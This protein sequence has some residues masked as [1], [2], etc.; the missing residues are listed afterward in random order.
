MEKFG[1]LDTLTL[2]EGDSVDLAFHPYSP[3]TIYYKS[4]FLLLLFTSKSIMHL[5]MLVLHH[6][7]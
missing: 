3:I 7:S 6:L 2:K 5:L 4:F 1:K